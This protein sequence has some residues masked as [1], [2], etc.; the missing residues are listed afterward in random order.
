MDAWS[1]KF[2]IITESIINWKPTFDKF[3]WF[4][5]WYW[6]HHFINLSDL[7][8]VLLNWHLISLQRMFNKC[9]RVGDQINDNK[10]A[11]Y[12]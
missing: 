12:S 4:V 7:N 8:K 6:T 2:T 11:K 5:K 10:Y 9:F 3:D 1:L